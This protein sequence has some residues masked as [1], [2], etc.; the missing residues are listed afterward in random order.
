MEDKTD[1]PVEHDLPKAPSSNNRRKYITMM[2]AGLIFGVAISLAIVWWLPKPN[3]IDY[4]QP[5]DTVS[6]PPPQT[7]A[8]F[9][10]HFANSDV[11]SGVL[12]E[13]REARG[14]HKIIAYTIA[15]CKKYID[16][17]GS[18][19]TMPRQLFSALMLDLTP[20]GE[21]QFTKVTAGSATSALRNK[22]STSPTQTST[23][24]TNSET[25][26]SALEDRQ[27]DSSNSSAI[28]IG[29]ETPI[30]LTN[31][32][33]SMLFLSDAIARARLVAASEADNN[34]PQMRVFGWFT[35]VIGAVATLLITVKA[36]MSS[37]SN[38]SLS[39]KGMAG[40]KVLY[41]VVGLLAIGLSAAGTALTSVKQFYDPTRAYKVSQA[42]LLQMKRL[43]N[44]IALE[45]VNN[46]D[47][48]SCQD[49]SNT[50]TRMQ[51]AFKEWSVA[52]GN[53]Q[54]SVIMASAN[55]QDADIAQLNLGT[56]GR[57]AAGLTGAPTV[58]NIQNPQPGLVSGTDSQSPPP[59]NPGRSTSTPTPRQ[60]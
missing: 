43:H 33:L 57:N 52:L 5:K 46:W 1:V 28:R 23:A 36:S 37:P 21:H 38:N 3:P 35:I 4:S 34:L 29:S 14:D 18:I 59:P 20:K 13:W 12:A 39:A 10:A 8:A 47:P 54:A 40:M 17:F 22:V 58:G 31:F 44:E 24:E 15:F 11:S 2:A 30:Q 41:I 25:A 26:P 49:D 56:I 50:R 16:R 48:A 32:E 27:I 19:D 55:L 7:E 51:A 42:A 45:F 53:L 60:P 9:L 6:E